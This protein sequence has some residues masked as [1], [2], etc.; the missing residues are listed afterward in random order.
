MN[1]RWRVASCTEASPSRIGCPGPAQ[2]FV[3][4]S[5]DAG[6]FGDLFGHRATPHEGA[7]P[8]RE[9]P[10]DAEIVQGLIGP[11]LSLPR[12]LSERSLVSEDYETR[13][14]RVIGVSTQLGQLHSAATA[15]SS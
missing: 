7:L 8:V 4:K 3:Q 1:T 14:D 9:G 5:D 6:A 2:P 12:R 10:I 11:R 15:S 13:I